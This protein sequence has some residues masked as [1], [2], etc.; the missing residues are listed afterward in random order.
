MFAYCLNNPVNGVDPNGLVMNP[1]IENEGGEAFLP[2]PPLGIPAPIFSGE[3]HKHILNGIMLALAF[4]LSELS[5]RQNKTERHHIV[6]RSSIRAL[7]ARVVLE[8]VYSDGVEN[9]NNIVVLS[10]DFHRRIHNSFYYIYVN[11]LVVGAFITG[12]FEGKAKQRELVTGVL[13]EIANTL[14]AM[15]IAF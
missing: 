5:T 9:P 4:G 12:S 10:Y 14:Q 3:Q 15:D 1:F 8:T 7:P 6:A 2:P 11:D 13:Q